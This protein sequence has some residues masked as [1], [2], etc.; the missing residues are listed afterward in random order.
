MIVLPLL[1]A[2]FIPFLYKAFPKIHTGWFVLAVPV[3]IFG[4]LASFLPMVASGQTAMLEVPWIPYFDINFD[5][6]V[7]GLGLIF[8]LIISGIGAL[9]V[10]IRSFTYRKRE[11]LSI[12]SMC[13]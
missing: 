8:A 13:I 2:V 1:F 9:V 10:V 12:I 3:V 4:Y 5:V 6:Y 7:D 11:K